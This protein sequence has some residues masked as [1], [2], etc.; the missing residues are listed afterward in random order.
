MCL[1]LGLLL[2]DIVDFMIFLVGCGLEQ[3][4][5]F[6]VRRRQ[7]RNQK[8]AYVVGFRDGFERFFTVALEVLDHAVEIRLNR[9]QV[10]L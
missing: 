5:R 8:L 3:F 9:G 10:L 4:G 6:L 7:V 2:L 1:R